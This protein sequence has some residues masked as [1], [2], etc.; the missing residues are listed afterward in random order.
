MNNIADPK[1]TFIQ[2]EFKMHLRKWV[3]NISKE[4]KNSFLL[5][6]GLSSN[7]KTWD[8]VGRLLSE[9]GHEAVAIDQR[10]HGLSEKTAS[11]FDF[12]TITADVAQVLD[13]LGW[14]SPILVGQSWGGNVL[15]EFGVR[16][17]NRSSGLVMVDGGFLNFG[18]TGESWET[19]SDRL[20]PPNIDRFPAETLRTLIQSSHQDWT[21]EGIDG[22]MANFKIFEDGSI[23]RHL[24]VEKHLQ[25]LR[26]LF[27]QNPQEL[28]PQIKEPVLICA[29]GPNDK[30]ESPKSEWLKQ[31]MQING[32][33]QQWF[34]HTDHDIHVQKPDA[35]VKTIFDWLKKVEVQE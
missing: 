4:S 21:D 22:T 12:E 9:A 27:D 23:E 19:V 30:P 31:A 29:A 18:T 8:G 2:L 15:T 32:V 13:H 20:K 16:Y 33:T 11:G 3:P 7:A 24:S 6:H 28:Y 34:A 26:H 35:L 10:N 17:P 25:I 14:D 1:Q 5:I